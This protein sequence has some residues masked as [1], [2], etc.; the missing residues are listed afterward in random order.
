MHVCVYVC[1]L[2]QMFVFVTLCIKH[3]KCHYKVIKVLSR[4]CDCVERA[5]I[6]EAFLDVTSLV[7]D[8]FKLL[9][10]TLPQD[11]PLITSSMLPATH[12]AGYSVTME[13]DSKGLRICSYVLL[14]VMLQYET[15]G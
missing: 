10:Q 9:Q 14:F 3:C 7:K 4:Y 8:R 12:V 5:S 13:T 6:D 1:I 11:C 15:S 2:V